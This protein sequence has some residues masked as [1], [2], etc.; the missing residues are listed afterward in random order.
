M[1][2]ALEQHA[3]KPATEFGAGDLLGVGPA[4]GGDV[5]GVVQP[6]L[7]EGNA[8]EELDAL[9]GEGAGGDGEGA[10]ARGLEQSLVG[11]IV[12]R[13]RRRRV[14]RV[15]G[16]ITGRQRRLPVVQMEARR[17]PPAAAAFRHP[18]RGKA[19]APEA[20][21]VVGKVGAVRVGVGGSVALEKL[22]AQH[23][24]DDQAV[25]ERRQTDRAGRDGARAGQVRHDIHPARP[26]EH[27]SIARQHHADVGVSLQRARQR[28]RHGAEPADLDEVAHFR[29][30]EQHALS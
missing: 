18:G 25:G 14:D 10:H 16:E 20:Q 7:E 12:D 3:V 6:R 29:G 13:Q 1:A 17:P 22:V 26:L 5:R 8:A 24:I 9:H 21:V 15:P 30:D 2:G 19:E 27:L 11:E 28:R 23:D 4:D